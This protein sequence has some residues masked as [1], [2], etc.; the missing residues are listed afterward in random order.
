MRFAFDIFKLYRR[1]G[2]S[3]KTSLKAAYKSWRTV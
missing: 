1:G 2:N 3:I